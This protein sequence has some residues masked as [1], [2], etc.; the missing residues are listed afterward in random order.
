MQDATVR[1]D[2]TSSPSVVIVGGGFAGLAAARGLRKVS[3][4]VHLIDQR[5]HHLFQPML[6]QVAMGQMMAGHI[7]EPLRE[8][9]GA[10]PVVRP[11]MDAVDGV[12]LDTRRV[13]FVSG[14]NQPYDMLVLATGARFQYLGHPHWG[15]H[16]LTLKNLKQAMTMRE[17]IFSAL[18]MAS[19]AGADDTQ[20]HAHL[21]FVIVGAGPTGVELAGAMARLLPGIIGNQFP[22]LDP[23]EL[24][25]VLAD[26]KDHALAGMH[27]SLS[28][29]ADRR[30]KSMG[31]DLMTG[32]AVE[33]IGRGRVQ[34]DNGQAVHASNI[35]WAAGMEGHGAGDWLPDALVGNGNKV[36]VG[37][38]LTLPGHP[39]VFVIG[40]AA[41]ATDDNDEP[42][43]GLAAVAKQQGTYVAHVIGA[44]L[45]EREDE[46][47]E[48]FHYTDY[49]TMAIISNGRAVGEIRGRRV[50]GLTAWMLWGLVHLYFLVSARKRVLVL[51]TWLWAMLTGR[52][53]RVVLSEAHPTDAAEAPATESDTVRA[54]DGS[55]P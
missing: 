33:D 49:G 31:V 4:N 35:I 24:R 53:Q 8:I 47:P 28:D 50:T 22:G 25:I 1:H 6:Y 23:D 38:D 54:T 14:A 46:P 36:P 12:D 37:A 13:H 44:R 42:Y 51:A 43:P 21:C 55:R 32:V 15:R 40:D 2:R 39:E 19:Q 52:R 48:R 45:N 7:A 20:R 30:L 16:V 27:P 26:P 29:Y 5:N 11:R 17:R 34:L 10:D 41:M 3:A 9:F 18:E